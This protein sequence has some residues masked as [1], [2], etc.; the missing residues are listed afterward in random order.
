MLDANIAGAP[1]VNK[2]GQIV[3]VLT[4]ADVIWKVGAAAGSAYPA[5][6]TA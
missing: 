3:G 2:S 6:C 1:V 4:E 5:D